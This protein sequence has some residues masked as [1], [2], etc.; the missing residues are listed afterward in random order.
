MSIFEQVIAQNFFVMGESAVYTPADTG[1]PVTIKVMASRPDEVFT[2]QSTPVLSETGVFEIQVSDIPN[3]QENDR[4]EF[5]GKTYIVQGDPRAADPDRLIW[6]LN[7]RL[8]E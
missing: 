2:F 3:P 6:R 4:L 5:K 8:E 1:A 7:T